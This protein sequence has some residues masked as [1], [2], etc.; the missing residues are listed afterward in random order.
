MDFFRCISMP[1]Y[2]PHPCLV[3]PIHAWYSLYMLGTP[4]IMVTRSYFVPYFVSLLLRMLI[5]ACNPM[6][7]PIHVC[8]SMSVC[9]CLALSLSLC[10][11]VSLSPSLSRSICLLSLSL[12]P[13]LPLSA[14]RSTYWSLSLSS[15]GRTKRS[16]AAPSGRTLRSSI[17]GLGLILTG[18]L[19]RRCMRDATKPHATVAIRVGLSLTQP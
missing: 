14:Y 16:S 7:C 9:L 8:L 6:V 1:P 10:L 11:S 15:P 4:P 18:F 19:P 2:P 5:G 17:I 13:P 3:L 12:L